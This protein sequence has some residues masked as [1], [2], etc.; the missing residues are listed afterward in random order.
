VDSLRSVDNFWVIV[1]EM[2]EFCKDEVTVT[3]VTVISGCGLM[4]PLPLPGKC[5]RSVASTTSN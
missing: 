3:I 1:A 5:N 2:E 4:F